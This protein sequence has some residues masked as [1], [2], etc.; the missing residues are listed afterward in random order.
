MQLELKKENKEED[1]YNFEELGECL[2]LLGR[3]KEAKPYFAKAHTLLKEDAYLQSQ[4]AERLKRLSEL[5]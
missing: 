5:S 4:E 2:L 3:S 1:G